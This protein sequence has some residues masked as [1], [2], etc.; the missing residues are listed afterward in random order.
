[1]DLTQFSREIGMKEFD[2]LVAFGEWGR[3]TSWIFYPGFGL[4]DWMR[5]CMASFSEV[6]GIIEGIC[7]WGVKIHLVS[8]RHA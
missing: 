1:M 3:E 8:Y 2:K 5:K 7:I 4:R 6:G